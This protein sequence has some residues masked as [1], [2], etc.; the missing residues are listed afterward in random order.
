MPGM[1]GFGA[2][3]H[4]MNGRFPLE[5][6]TAQRRAIRSVLDEAGRPLSPREVLSAGRDHVPSLGMATVYRTLNGLVTEG[7]LTAVE[8]PGEPPRYEI[9]GKPHHHHFHCRRCDQVFEVPGCPGNLGA[10]V[11]K[12][13]QLEAHEVVLYGSCAQCA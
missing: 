6:D 11:P 9:A 5:R 8:L 10:V 7:A 1:G 4:A 3:I 12:G 2:D 13:F